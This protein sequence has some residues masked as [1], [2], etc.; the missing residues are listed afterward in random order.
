M[1]IPFP[2]YAGSGHRWRF[3]P[4][5]HACIP[6]AALLLRGLRKI[7]L[8]L[9]RFYFISFAT[10][11]EVLVTELFVS[12]MSVSPLEFTT[13]PRALH[14]RTPLDAVAWC[15]PTR[16]PP[17]T[18]PGSPPSQIWSLER[19]PSESFCTQA[20]FPSCPI[21]SRYTPLPSD[22]SYPSIVGATPRLS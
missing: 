9:D 2:P 21:G 17:K 20:G 15:N 10:Y 14:H 22:F 12:T 1:L 13:A 3:T 6:F 4:R 5:W 7:P 11:L 16:T 8:D 18:Y 19:P